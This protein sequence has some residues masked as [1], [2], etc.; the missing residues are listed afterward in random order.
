MADASNQVQLACIKC[1]STLDNASECRA[2]SPLRSSP[3]EANIAR[4]GEIYIPN[5]GGIGIGTMPS[6]EPPGTQSSSVNSKEV[7]SSGRYELTSLL[8]ARPSTGLG[9][10]ANGTRMPSIQ[11]KLAERTSLPVEDNCQGTGAVPTP[12]G[13]PIGK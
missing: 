3:R 8:A 12:P 11:T 10:I 9:I 13:Q 2:C 1:G 6:C 5:Y 4:G 7:F